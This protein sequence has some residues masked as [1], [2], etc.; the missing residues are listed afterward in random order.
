MSSCVSKAA[1][2]HNVGSGKVRRSAINS[3]LDRQNKGRL[4]QKH[5]PSLLIEAVRMKTQGLPHLH[6]RACGYV[7]TTPLGLRSSARDHAISIYPALFQGQPLISPFSLCLATHC[8]KTRTSAPPQNIISDG[9]PW[10]S[11]NKTAGYVG[12]GKIPGW[13]GSKVLEKKTI[14]SS[15][16]D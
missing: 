1:F 2:N 8:Y 16:L 11:I 4:V 13:T 9:F 6:E 5:T 14:P 3:S 12:Q 10:F 7:P 15:N